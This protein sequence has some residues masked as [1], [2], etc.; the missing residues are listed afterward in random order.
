[1]TKRSIIPFAMSR[2]TLEIQNRASRPV[3][4]ASTETRHFREFFG[5]SIHVVEKVWAAR[6]TCFGPFICASAGA[7]DPK[8]R[9]K[10]VWAFIDAVASLVNV[11]VSLTRSVGTGAGVM[12]C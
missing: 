2:P 12:Y 8:T 11:T 5:A 10:W 7:I 3:R 6:S 9:R 1:M 4:V